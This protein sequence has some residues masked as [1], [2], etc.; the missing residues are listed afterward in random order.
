MFCD[1]PPDEKGPVVRQKFLLATPAVSRR[2]LPALLACLMLTLAAALP[3]AAAAQEP[4]KD[5]DQPVEDPNRKAANISWNPKLTFDEWK[6]L[7]KVR[8]IEFDRKL[9]TAA[10]TDAEKKP[11]LKHLQNQINGLTLE[12]NVDRHAIIV[13]NITRAAEHPSTSPAVRE[14]VY[15]NA[16][17]LVESLL[18][19]QPP[20]VQYSLVLLVSRLNAKAPNLTARPP[21]PS[22]PYPPSQELL[23]RVL[24]TDPPMPISVRII[25]ARGLERLMRDGDISTVDKSQIGETL[26]MGLKQKVDNPLAR[27][28]Y[29]WKLVEGLGA[30][31][32]YE[33]TGYKPVMID[34]LMSV[35]TNPQ[36]DW[37]V[38][39]AAARSISQLP[40]DQKVNVELVNYEVVRFLHDLAVAYS[41]SDKTPPSTWRWAFDNVY[42][43]YKAPTAA[44]QT[45]KHWGLMHLNTPR[46]REQIN[47]AYKNV[48]LPVVKPILESQALPAID[49]AKI[50]ALS[51]W[52]KSNAVT[53]RKVTPG[54]GDLKAPA[55]APPQAVQQP[56]GTA[57]AGAA[58]N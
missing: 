25:A 44:D 7:D 16:L 15:E 19:D 20:N 17:K 3:T 46:G 9:G 49:A 12:Q 21:V 4:K 57:A 10:L 53:D 45:V 1:H 29:R 33:E 2:R 24:V 28:W 43:A 11:L 37:E 39:A 36:D 30:T 32:R 13:D 27:K 18:K 56:N 54:S 41:A 5:D 23:K 35:L 6:A 51:D 38:R 22:Q 48:V 47:A 8:F 58:G 50:K 42:L 31:G 14:F 55:G 34:A 26:A 52:L 40:L